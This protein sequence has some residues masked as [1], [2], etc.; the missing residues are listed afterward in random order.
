MHLD[1]AQALLLQA[2]LVDLTTLPS[3]KPP[4]KQ[5]RWPGIVKEM[6]A[7]V[8]TKAVMNSWDK[9]FACPGCG[10]SFEKKWQQLEHSLND[11]DRIEK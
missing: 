8:A 9:E 2:L 1:R 3:Y 7:A 11:C 10:E 6:R 4:L 5:K